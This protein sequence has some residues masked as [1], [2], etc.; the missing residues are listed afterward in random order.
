[1]KKSSAL[2]F[3]F[4]SIIIGILIGSISVYFLIHINEIKE[5]EKNNK[6]TIN[7]L[8]QKVENLKNL[9]QRLELIQIEKK[10]KLKGLIN[11]IKNKD[12]SV[13]TKSLLLS[14]DITNNLDYNKLLLK[15]ELI[16]NINTETPEDDPDIK[17]IKEAIDTKTR[18]IFTSTSFILKEK[19]NKLNIRIMDKNQKLSDTNLELDKTNSTLDK[20]NIELN[21]NIISINKYQNKLEL[22]NKQ[23]QENLNEIKQ[24]KEKLE[25][26]KE[27]IFSL[28]KI[29][30]EL[31]KSMSALETKLEDG[32][33]KVSFKG[34][35]LFASGSHTLKPEG[36]KLIDNVFP[37]LKKNIT[38]NNIFIAG[39]TDNEKIIETTQSKYESNWDLSTYR[40]IEVVKYLSQKG[41][42]PINITA[43]GF[44]KF[45][46]IADN[47]TKAGRQKNRRVEL[48]LI[49]KI[50]RRNNE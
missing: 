48:F 29:E 28:R 44:G 50:I 20:K 26:H 25:L 40:A 11:D 17:K 49:P 21:E 8:S 36:K 30:L 1:M 39:H 9:N 10:K 22:Q 23:L 38:N 7:S 4:M 43:A 35:I 32:K 33:L 37:I 12:Y 34:D 18:E 15:P 2:Y 47:S 16:Q 14:K 19:I 24:Y 41:I 31:N 45:R 42:K 3:S 6:T 5:I 27:Q 46:P 13:L